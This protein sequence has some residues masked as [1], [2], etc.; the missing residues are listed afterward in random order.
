MYYRRKILLSLLEVF[1]NELEKI[2][3]QKLLML[4]NEF[5]EKPSYDFVP[6]KY[7]CFSF[8]ANADLNTMIKYKQI[9]NHENSWRR[10]DSESYIKNLTNS[11]KQALLKLKKN[12]GKATT[13]DLIRMWF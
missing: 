3:L 7:G 1:G 12:F 4:L 8:Q 9:E 6:Y 13:M 5:Q 11:D 10:I 2:Q